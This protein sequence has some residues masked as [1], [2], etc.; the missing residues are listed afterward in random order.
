[1]YLYNADMFCDKCAEAFKR[2]IATETLSNS[3]YG[4]LEVY[5]HYLE[6]E[7]T[8]IDDFIEAADELVAEGLI[9]SNAWPLYGAETATDSPAHCGADDVCLDA[10]VLADRSVGA[11]LS[12][13]LTAYGEEYVREAI[14]GGGV[15]ADLWAG[16]WPELV[17]DNDYDEEDE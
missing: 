10:I 12:E 1:M 15:V 9:D 6:D 13:Q 5:D 14:M 8:D 4:C 3:G 2:E 11:L 16:V 17:S 7:F